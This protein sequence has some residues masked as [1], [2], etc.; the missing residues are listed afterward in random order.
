MKDQLIPIEGKTYIAAEYDENGTRWRRVIRVFQGYV[1]Y[2][3]G[4]NSNRQCL[5]ATFQRWMRKATIA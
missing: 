1:F 3:I 5:L 4:G 2:S